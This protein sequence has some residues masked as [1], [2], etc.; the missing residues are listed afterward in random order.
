MGRKV[1]DKFSVPIC[2]LHY[3]ELHRRGNEHAWWESQGIEPLHIAAML[4]D[5]A[6]VAVPGAANIAGDGPTTIN[7]K[8]DGHFGTNAASR[9]QKDETKPIVRPEAE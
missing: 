2:R 3:R 1:S 4:W 5:K 8:P 7:G 6:H 9:P